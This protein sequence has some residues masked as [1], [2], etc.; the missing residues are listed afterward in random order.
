MARGLK[1]PSF[2][3]IQNHFAI[4][5]NLGE[6]AAKVIFFMHLLCAFFFFQI[7][8]NGPFFHS[9]GSSKGKFFFHVSPVSFFFFNFILLTFFH[10]HLLLWVSI[11]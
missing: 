5:G 6:V 2:R 7:L 11:L 1:D 4:S 10:P 9:R 3:V 8:V